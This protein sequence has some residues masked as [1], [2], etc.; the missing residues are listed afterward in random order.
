MCSYFRNGY[1]YVKILFPHFKIQHSERKRW[2][3]GSLDLKSEPTMNS[4]LNCQ[5]SD[6]IKYFRLEKSSRDFFTF[7]FQNRLS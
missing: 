7:L 5:H 6:K 4:I 2:K 3:N 1:F